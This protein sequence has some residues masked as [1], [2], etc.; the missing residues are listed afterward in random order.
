MSQDGLGLSREDAWGLTP[1]EIAALRQV[2]DDR[3]HMDLRRWAVG[4]ADMRNLVGR[5]DPP[6]T[7]E[8][9]LGQS[10]RAARV[11]EH[12]ADKQKAEFELMRMQR[13][14]SSINKDSP[15]LPSWAI[16]HGSGPGG[17]WSPE[18][19]ARAMEKLKA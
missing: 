13:K 12:I 7:V 8:E 16:C 2:R 9:V 4:I 5:Q 11:A 14:M 3:M 15:E 1:R 19:V 6:W 17:G 10:D 18:E